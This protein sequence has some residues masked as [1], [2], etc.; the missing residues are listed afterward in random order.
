MAVVMVELGRP[1][2]FKLCGVGLG[3]YNVGNVIVVATAFCGLF[4]SFNSLQNFETSLNKSLGFFSLGIL[5]TCLALST[6]I[7]PAVVRTLG[8]RISLCIGAFTYCMFIAANIHVEAYILLPVAGIMGVGAG[9]L[10]TAQG[11]H[12]AQSSDAGQ[13]G[14][15]SGLFFSIF[16]INQVTGNLLVAVLL[17]VGINVHVVIII[18]TGIALLF[19]LLLLAVKP[20]YPGSL[21]KAPVVGDDAAA[22][23]S[24]LAQAGSVQDTE[25]GPDLGLPTLTTRELV[26]ETL[27]L[28]GK[29]RLQLLILPMFYSG[30]TQTYYFGIFPRQVDLRMIG[31]LM[32]CFGSA[33]ASLSLILGKVSD[34]IGRR[35]IL[36]AGAFACVVGVLAANAV[37]HFDWPSWVMFP[38]AVALGAADASYNT[39]LYAILG[40]F[41]PEHRE[42]AFAAFKAVQAGSTGAAF[43]A[44]QFASFFVL[45]AALL[46]SLVLGL[47]S[48]VIL[49][50]WVRPLSS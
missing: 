31:W 14:K 2:V 24:L 18:L 48:L 11:A 26:L 44:S 1:E 20:T 6:F 46:G 35:P 33:D 47:I 19:S 12:L 28:F 29:L 30:L 23:E 37:A 17:H 9:V 22:A 43:A 7:A 50:L 42:A 38:A 39:Q 21:L 36:F 8:N 49:D 41:F 40:S 45:S 16:Q 13:M 34:R 5:Y 4:T 25:A 3:E 15:M 10:W 27:H 32:A